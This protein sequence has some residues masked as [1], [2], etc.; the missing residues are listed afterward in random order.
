MFK[1]NKKIV[2]NSIKRFAKTVMKKIIKPKPHQN[3]LHQSGSYGNHSRGSVHSRFTGYRGS[4]A[5]TKPVKTYRS[6]VIKNVRHN[7]KKYIKKHIVKPIKKFWRKLW[8]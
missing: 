1:R 5:G 2:V 4:K 8:R 3:V 7:A 6:K